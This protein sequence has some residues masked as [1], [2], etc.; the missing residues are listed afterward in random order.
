MMD[1]CAIRKDFPQLR[2]RLNGKPLIYLDST[3]T[4]LKPSAVINKINEYYTKYSAN[5][6]RGIYKTSEEATAEYEDARG[7]VAAFIGANKPEEVVFTR[8]TSESINLIAYSWGKGNLKKGDQVVVTIM[9]HHSNFVP[10][11]QMA[12]EKSLKFRV[13]GLE[14][15]AT[16][17]L[18]ELD[19]LITR[20][21]KLLAITAVSNVLGTINPVKTIVRTV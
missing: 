15:D 4:S 3:A 6:F 9:E 1:A 13:R 12:K 5:I 14:K 2:R 8:N 20:R 18:K 11:Q 10:W 17:N 7:K 16:L 21:T 19:K